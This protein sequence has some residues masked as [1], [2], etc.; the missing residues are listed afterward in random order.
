MALAIVNGAG[1]DARLP[2]LRAGKDATQ[3][4]EEIG[5]SNSAREM[6]NKYYIGDFAVRLAPWSVVHLGMLE[7]WQPCFIACP[8]AACKHARANPYASRAQASTA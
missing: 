5:H 3:D 1:A 7:S 6:L 2:C 8:K 4:F